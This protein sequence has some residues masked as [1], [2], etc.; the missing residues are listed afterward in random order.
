MQCRT[1]TCLSFLYCQLLSKLTLLQFFR[2]TALP[3]LSAHISWRQVT[4]VFGYFGALSSGFKWYL[5]HAAGEPK[6]MCNNKTHPCGHMLG[7]NVVNM[8]LQ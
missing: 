8:F 6:K 3:A 5:F 1:G 4:V 7:N 2:R